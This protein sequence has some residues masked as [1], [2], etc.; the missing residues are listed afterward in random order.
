MDSNAWND[1]NWTEYPEMQM[2]EA[3]FVE[4]C[5]ELL[6]NNYSAPAAVPFLLLIYT[7]LYVYNCNICD[8]GPDPER[9]S[10]LIWVPWEFDS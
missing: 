9:I 1:V 3:G 5:A 8:L 6:I 7:P 4:K 10:N 2:F